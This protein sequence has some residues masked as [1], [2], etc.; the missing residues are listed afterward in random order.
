MKQIIDDLKSCVTILM[1]LLL[2]IVVIASLAG[3]KLEEDLLILVT[4]L[5]TSV[6]TYYFARQKQ[7]EGSKENESIHE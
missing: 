2:Y 5:V 7:N 3:Y 6:F 1:I 4:N